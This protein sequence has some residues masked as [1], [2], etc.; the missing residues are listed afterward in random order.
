M[1]KYLERKFQTFFLCKQ[2]VIVVGKLCWHC[3]SCACLLKAVVWASWRVLSWLKQKKIVLSQLYS[4]ILLLKFYANALRGAFTRHNNTQ[5]WLDTSVMKCEQV[6]VWSSVMMNC[7]K[8]FM[9]S[10]SKLSFEKCFPLEQTY[11]NVRC[12]NFPYG[13][14]K[15]DCLKLHS[16]S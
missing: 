3:F 10:K 2:A 16:I 8:F 9:S 1:E 13:T 6:K 12:W 5:E 14:E 11:G 4:P 15:G 7:W